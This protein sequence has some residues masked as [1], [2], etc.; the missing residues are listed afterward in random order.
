[1]R[2]GFDPDARVGLL[3]LARTEIELGELLGRKVDLNTSGFLSDYFC[4]EVLAEAETQYGA[5]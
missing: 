1:M 5:A 2:A 4:D 3:G